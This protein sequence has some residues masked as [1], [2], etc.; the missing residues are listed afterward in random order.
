VEE[1]RSA[2]EALEGSETVEDLMRLAQG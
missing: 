1:L 2:L